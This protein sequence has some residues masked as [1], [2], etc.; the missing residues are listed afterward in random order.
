MTTSEFAAKYAIT[1]AEKKAINRFEALKSHALKIIDERI[2]E[3]KPET[4]N[5]D[6]LDFYVEAFVN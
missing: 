5:N 3:R 4:K 6:I 2:E 1:S